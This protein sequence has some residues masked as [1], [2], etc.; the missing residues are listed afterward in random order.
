M[1][2]LLARALA[3]LSTALVSVALLTLPATA[4]PPFR[5]D[6]HVVDR[7]S[8][9]V[10]DGDTAEVEAAI[11]QLRSQTDLDLFIVFVDSFDGTPAEEWANQTAESS[12]LGNLDLLF[13]VATVDRE[14]GWSSTDAA[15]LSSSQLDAAMSRAQD[16]FSSGDWAE[17][18]VTFA[19]EIT[20]ASTGGGGGGLT[21]VLVVGA[22]LVA[23]VLLVVVLRSR[24]KRRAGQPVGAGPGRGAPVEP[25]PPPDSLEAKL[26]QLSTEELRTR[27]GSA[28][29][30]LD[31]AVR[32][33][34]QE[35][36]FAEAQFGLQA[37]QSFSTALTTAKGHL[38]E[39][40]G[41]QARLEDSSP[42]SEAE[43]RGML[44]R[45]V[46]LCA[47]ADDL[48]DDQAEAFAHLRNLREHA[49]EALNEIEQRAGEI[50]ATIP[51]AELAL[52][53]LH[54]T[55]PDSALTSVARAPQ[56]A[57]SLLAAAREAVTSGRQ[58]LQ[59]ND[60]GGAVAYART[61]EDAL[62]QAVT[63]IESVHQGSTELAEAR[64]KLD[65]A[66]DSIRA[67][68]IDAGNLGAGDSGVQALVPR[69][70]NAI[71][72]AIA[73]KE[74]GDPIAALAEIT[75][76]ED[77]L[78]TALAPHREEAET[79]RRATAKL[80]TGLQRTEALI[81][82]TNDFIATNRGA[83]GPQAR[84]ALADATEL[85]RQAQA[86]Q[87]ERP[88]EAV[89]LVNRS[90]AAATRARELATA[91]VNRWHHDQ[92]PP[93]GYGGRR[94]SDVDVGSLIL[95]GLLGAALGG[96]RRG[97]F[98]GFGGFGGGFGGSG[99]NSGRMGGGGGFGGGRIGG[100]GRF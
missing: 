76:A 30:Q 61:A 13:A 66:I 75:S 37:I 39:A 8:D 46:L 10:L 54:A 19:E 94:G 86:L 80:P 44:T 57:R 12:G 59:E 60:R 95:G 93:G 72:Q 32:S 3:A 31:D 36:G 96:G 73:A 14:T 17:G 26:A 23:V 84:T 69:A 20:S 63:L 77:A 4:E 42:E 78:D 40:F 52:T 5:V 45:I 34:D 16:H 71:E 51:P 43:Q 50:E 90:W 21:V 89:E 6:A 9:G 97:G 62:Q 24:A 79:D 28:L 56:Q 70:N 83:V 88:R 49:P 22:V 2:R 98:G 58:R 29:V 92:R 15:G 91:D 7:T 99:W 48:L 35:L 65:P 82:S 11:E 33:S 67:D 74:T 47:Q 81:R 1:T 85:L 55:Y 25:P 100:G 87:R 53:Q 38:S 18:A 64:A 41:I 27:A 68:L